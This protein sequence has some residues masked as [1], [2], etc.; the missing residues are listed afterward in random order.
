MNQGLKI[1]LWVVG[2]LALGTGAY[3]AISAL[4]KP[5]PDPN[6]PKT[7]EEKKAEALEQTL[8][9]TV[10]SGE[11]TTQTRIASDVFPLKIDRGSGRGGSEGLWVGQFQLMLNYLYNAGLTIDGKVGQALKKAVGSYKTIYYLS[12]DRVTQYLSST[13]CDIPKA[14]YDDLIKEII[15]KDGA[16]GKFLNYMN[17]NE[18]WKK[19]RLKFK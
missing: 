18:D 11:T 19:L 17:T 13:A 12:C 14:Y 5:K 16:V 9:D 15:K 1:T 2:G 8:K 7:E 6:K 4:M 10:G 3:F